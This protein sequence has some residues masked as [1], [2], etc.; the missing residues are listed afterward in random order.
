MEKTIE[1]MIED[2][3]LYWKNYVFQS[4]FAA[5]TTFIVLLVLGLQQAVI[6]AS[7]GATAFIV[8]AM[9][10]NTT[11]RGRN[12]IGGH[13]VG[14]ICGSLCTLIPHPTFL[15]SIIVYSLA[16]GLSIFIMVI[17]NTEHPPASGTALGVVLRGLSLEVTI[18]VITSAIML[19][20]VHH[21]FKRYL[22]DLT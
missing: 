1:K 2:F 11:A 7:I 17:T 15:S 5:F 21:Y 18:A 16:V 3:R 13:T 8:F 19:A 10:K 9:P 14:L 22:K 12:V 6:I 20:L 4:L